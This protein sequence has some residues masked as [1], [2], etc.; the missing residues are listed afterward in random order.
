MQSSDG[1]GEVFMKQ[2]R[3]KMVLKQRK[4]RAGKQGLEEGIPTAWRLKG[5]TLCKNHYI[6]IWVS[7]ASTATSSAKNIHSL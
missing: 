7:A 2:E 6:S 5:D 3:L 4:R 1:G